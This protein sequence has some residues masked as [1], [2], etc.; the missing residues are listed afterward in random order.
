MVIWG[1]HILGNIHLNMSKLNPSFSNEKKN[2]F[3]TSTP[4]RLLEASEAP[5][6]LRALLREGGVQATLQPLFGLPGG[7]GMEEGWRSH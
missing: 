2:K 5:R 3:P 1:T 6:K 4:L 7:T